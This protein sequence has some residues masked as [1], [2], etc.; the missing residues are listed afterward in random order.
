VFGGHIG[1]GRVGKPPASMTRAA[2]LA[3]IGRL[4]ELM[5][6]PSELGPERAGIYAFYC[7]SGL[8][9]DAVSMEASNAEL[10]GRRWYPNDVRR[11]VRQGRAWME[12]KL[13]AAGLLLARPYRSRVS[14]S[15][16]RRMAEAELLEW[17]R[18]GA[19]DR[20]THRRIHERSLRSVN[21]LPEEGVEDAIRDEEIRQAGR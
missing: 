16:V 17:E 9:I 21:P 7:A 6:A 15:T 10:G 20:R 18:V 4:I 13:R 12:R 19:G 11:A 2:D 1:G 14:P 8:S 5:E 3:P